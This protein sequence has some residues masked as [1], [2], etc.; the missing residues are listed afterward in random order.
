MIP[1]N[2]PPADGIYT[3]NG[4][5]ANLGRSFSSLL[6]GM[7]AD[8]EDFPDRP[9]GSGSWF[10]E[11]PRR[12]ENAASQCGILAYLIGSDRMLLVVRSQTI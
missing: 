12:P 7:S 8:D 10:A 11:T 5:P 1:A 4:R 3:G 9:P 2:S 6:A